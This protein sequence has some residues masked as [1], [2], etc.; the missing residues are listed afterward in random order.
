MISKMATKQFEAMRE[1]D[2]EE[3]R[4]RVNVFTESVQY[5]ITHFNRHRIMC[6]KSL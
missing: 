4:T 3:L 6:I 1:K 5:I 2:K